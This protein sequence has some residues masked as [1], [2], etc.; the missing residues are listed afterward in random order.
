MPEEEM[1]IAWL[2]LKRGVPV[3]TSDGEEVGHV[4]SVIA[5]EQKDI[6]SGIAFRDHLLAHER[7]APA[8]IIETLTTK[9][10]HLSIDKSG[11]ID[12]GGPPG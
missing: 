6:F 5:D 7:F 4:S 3:F 11:A 1:P 8:A 2:A 9:G 12:L 10:V